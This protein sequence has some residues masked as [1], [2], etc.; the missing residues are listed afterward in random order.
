MTNK[1][2][3]QKLSISIS[4]ETLDRVK[5]ITKILNIR[6]LD[7]DKRPSSISTIVERL[8]RAGYEA[9]KEGLVYEAV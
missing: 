8:I 7:V 1:E 2:N 9:E 5:E 4:K 3:K 6:E